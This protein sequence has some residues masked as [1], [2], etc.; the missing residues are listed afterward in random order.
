M[1]FVTCCLLNPSFADDNSVKLIDSK[2]HSMIDEA[3]EK[4]EYDIEQIDMD[5]IFI[6]ENTSHIN[7]KKNIEAVWVWVALPIKGTEDISYVGFDDG[8]YI[9]AFTNFVSFDGMM[10]PGDSAYNKYIS[11]NGLSDPA[12]VKN[13]WISERVHV[14]AFDVV[15][16]GE[17]YIIPYYFTDESSFNVMKSDECIIQLGKAYTLDEFVKICEKESVLYD[18]YRRELR[19]KENKVVVSVDK[20]GDEI[21]KVGDINIDELKEDILNHINLAN[22]GSYVKMNIDDRYEN[23]HTYIDTSLKKEFSDFVDNLFE[24]INL[25][26]KEKCEES[27]SFDSSC[28][29][30]IKYKKNDK[31][32]IYNATINISDDAV[33]INVPDY[34]GIILKVKNGSKIKEYLIQESENGFDSFENDNVENY[35]PLILGT[36]D[37]LTKTDI[38]EFKF[39]NTLKGNNTVTDN[40]ASY[41]SMVK[42]IFEKYRENKYKSTYVLTLSGDMGE[43]SFCVQKQ[44]SLDGSEEIFSNNTPLTFFD[45]IRF[46]KGDIVEYKNIKSGDTYDFEMYFKDGDITKVLFEDIQ[47]KEIKYL[48]LTEDTKLYEEYVEKNKEDIIKNAKECADVLY[49]VG[50]FKGT[51]NGY[52]LE[53]SLTREES[54]TI[55][56][57]LL[58]KE[59]YSAEENPEVFLDVDKTRWSY[60]YIMYCYNNNI[61]KGTSNNTF[62]P[63]AEIDAEQFVTLLMRL[64]GY[65][66]ITP[67]TALKKSVHYELLS[68]EMVDSLKENETFIRE[69][70]VQIVYN[71][72]KT[73]MN[74]GKQFSDYLLEQGVLTES[75][76]DIIE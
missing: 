42:G 57:R 2:Y 66:D 64:L 7:M 37:T 1:V 58:G 18:E 72:L 41:N 55:L 73:N 62:S 61:T 3:I 28:I 4:S 63:E 26:I 44:S 47:C 71:S 10:V 33:E 13:M 34:D 31:I 39:N 40:V 67:E 11:D 17:E 69:N 32:S 20:D 14:F 56:V 8:K 25:Q 70:M 43:V 27:R 65:H 30:R 45:N 52:E 48:S 51:D 49:N 60:P 36:T 12:K 29:I 59:D 21:V 24:E 76:L 19:E 38:I 9:K 6:V 16:D 53:K 54:A 75:N 22:E 74:D 46:E 35:K 50:L 15:C 68:Q 5:R 23:K